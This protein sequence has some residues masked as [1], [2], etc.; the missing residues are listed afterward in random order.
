[1]K[2]ITKIC[3]GSLI[4][5]TI[6]PLFVYAMY[7]NKDSFGSINKYDDGILTGYDETQNKRTSYSDDIEEDSTQ[8]AKVYVTQAS[9]FGV[10]I[11]KKI[12][13][14][15]ESDETKINTGNY[16]IRLANDTNISGT[17]VIKVIPD[18]TFK[19]SQEGKN[20]I[21]VTVTQD[22]KD[23]IYNEIDV[24]GNGV[25]STNEMSA[26]SWKGTFNF[27]IEL[28]QTSDKKPTVDYAN[29]KFEDLTWDD[30]MA[31]SDSNEFFD[32]YELGATKT[33]EYE[34]NTY[35]AEVVGVNTY[36]EGEITF[37]TK[38]ILPQ[39][40][41]MNYTARNDGGWPNSDLRNILNTTI[42]NGLPEDLRSVI[43]PKTLEYESSDGSFYDI[44]LTSATDNL[45]L[46]TQYEVVGNWINTQTSDSYWK[47]LIN[48]ISGKQKTYEIYSH[49]NTSKNEILQK[50]FLGVEVDW[51]FSSPSLSSSTMFERIAADGDA[52]SHGI[53]DFER[54]VSIN[55]II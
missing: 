48:A 23:W 10:F 40:Y 12:I 33:F 44:T 51:W 31:L 29:T 13:L 15:G 3:I 6:F 41:P 36:N 34:G 1:M 45:W 39:K 53:A 38:E 17:E 26:G 20:D 11:P 27:N 32:Y 19:M 22:K 54:G 5:S 47:N 18:E 9:A 30:I 8:T 37:M 28:E 46:P 35:T 50:K 2:K 55:F 42:Y 14:N 16:I 43:T 24:I 7:T 21:N 4:I 52:Y 25:V 49:I